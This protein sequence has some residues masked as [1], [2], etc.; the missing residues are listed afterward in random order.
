[1]ISNTHIKNSLLLAATVGSLTTL[2]AYAVGGPA[3]CQQKIGAS[4]A[5]IECAN[6]TN[7]TARAQCGFV[8]A[9]FDANGHAYISYGNDSK[10]EATLGFILAKQSQKSRI[11][12]Y[13]EA[14]SG[15]GAEDF[16]TQLNHIATRMSD[17]NTNSYGFA[18]G[19]NCLVIGVT[20]TMFEPKGG[21][22]LISNI[23]SLLVDL[24]GKLKDRASDKKKVAIFFTDYPIASA[25]NIKT[26]FF[27]AHTNPD[28]I[29]TYN[30]NAQLVT[31]SLNN[32]KAT[33]FTAGAPGELTKLALGTPNLGAV[34]AWSIPG[35]RVR[36]ETYS[37]NG[38]PQ[39][40]LPSNLPPKRDGVPI[41]LLQGAAPSIH[42]DRLS[43]C[44]AAKSLT[45]SIYAYF[46]EVPP[47]DLA[48][49]ECKAQ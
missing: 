43:S 10:Y 28:P 33:R 11:R 6:E 24:N 23:D 27:N 46:G 1:M 29:A 15:A 4:L 22:A 14:V 42:P 20:R 30:A 25:M 9:S 17:M 32:L 44:S 12:W 7:T 39:L 34:A 48:G 41:T 2:P 16:R 35:F 38:V 36:N 21:E 31:K 8:G 37:A 19:I 13:N 5:N 18:N 49:D 40:K 3:S 47:A 45:N 26:A